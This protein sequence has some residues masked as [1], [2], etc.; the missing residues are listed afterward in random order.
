MNP[1]YL[2]ILGGVI[3]GT[4][5]GLIEVLLTVAIQVYLA[6]ARRRP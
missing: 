6:R 1:L 4:M 3:G 2:A 5:V